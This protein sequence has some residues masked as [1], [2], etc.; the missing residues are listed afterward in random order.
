MRSHQMLMLSLILFALG[1]GCQ[2]YSM[3]EPSEPYMQQMSFMFVAMPSVMAILNHFYYNQT[4]PSHTD[5]GGGGRGG[6]E[7]KTNLPDT[8][9]T[10]TAT[11]SKPTHKRT[12]SQS[13]KNTNHVADTSQQRDN[14]HLSSYNE[15]CTE[16]LLFGEYK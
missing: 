11:P 2:V 5:S 8:A 1:I 14:Q 4:P 13:N 9:T 7:K 15:D 10:T 16:E 12:L 6:E 3:F